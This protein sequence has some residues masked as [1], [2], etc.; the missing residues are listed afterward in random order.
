MERFIVSYVESGLAYSR[1]EAWFVM[2][3]LAGQSMDNVLKSEGP[4]SEM[5]AIKVHHVFLV[6]CG[7]FF[8]S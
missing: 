3:H 8:T 5:S 4:I 2:E 7:S 6:A 1:R